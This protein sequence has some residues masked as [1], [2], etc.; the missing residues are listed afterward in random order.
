MEPISSPWVVPQD[1]HGVVPTRGFV[2]V[3][4]ITRVL[5]L[6][7]QILRVCPRPCNMRICRERP[8]CVSHGALSGSDEGP[9]WGTA[10]GQGSSN[11]VP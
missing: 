4:R 7:I 6:Q 3:V 8:G 10:A 5:L 9:A 11:R 1:G 2:L